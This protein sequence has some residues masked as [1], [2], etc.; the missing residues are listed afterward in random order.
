MA[1]STSNKR[2]KKKRSKYNCTVMK[3]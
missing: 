1:I 2:R 3:I